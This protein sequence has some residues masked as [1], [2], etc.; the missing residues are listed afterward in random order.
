MKTNSLHYLTKPSLPAKKLCV[1]GTFF[2][3][4][5]LGACLLGSA[6]Y[7][8]MSEMVDEYSTTYEDETP[9]PTA[10]VDDAN[11]EDSEHET[12]THTEFTLP[13]PT[14]KEA[15]IED[16]G[17]KRKEPEKEQLEVWEDSGEH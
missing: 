4:G 14:T 13:P 8:I 16:R 2:F 17:K 7:W 11:I 5:L 15:N 9:I 10:I 6:S 1:T 12:S 3:V